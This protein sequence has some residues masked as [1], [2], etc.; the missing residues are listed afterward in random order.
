MGVAAVGVSPDSPEKLK[1]F[2]KKYRLEFPLLSDGDHQVARAY[3]AWGEKN[4]YGK[5]SEGIIR[6]SFLIDE[7]GKL[8]GVWYK[9]S[10]KDTI[11]KAL[12]VLQGK[13]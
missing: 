8:R 11:P 13:P 2:D 5:K 12:E 10:P 9:V 6:S 3:G 7:A 4:L 1:S